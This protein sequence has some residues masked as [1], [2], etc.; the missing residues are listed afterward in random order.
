MESLYNHWTSLRK[1]ELSV[2]SYK[3]A[4]IGLLLVYL[5]V[6]IVTNLTHLQIQDVE[7]PYLTAAKALHESKPLNVVTRESYAKVFILSQAYKLST[8]GPEW[9]QVFLLRLSGLLFGAG[10][11]SLIYFTGKRIFAKDLF[12]PLLALMLLSVSLAFN[13]QMFLMS[14]QAF[15]SFIFAFL[16]YELVEVAFERRLLDLGIALILVFLLSRLQP[17]LIVIS[18]ILLVSTVV[19]TAFKEYEGAIKQSTSKSTN[20]MVTTRIAMAAGFLLMYLAYLA[21]TVSKTV[22]LIDIASAGRTLFMDMIFFFE[23]DIRSL[24]IFLD[25]PYYISIFAGL[26]SII[27]VLFF[28]KNIFASENAEGKSKPASLLV[29][30]EGLFALFLLL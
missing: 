18:V 24:G 17:E 29:A 12:T 3:K 26:L 25:F 27:G 6:G 23:V 20:S 4:F 21:F 15:I 11:L 22:K 8:S 9:L 16:L 14:G 28:I 1:R 10:I 13:T 19:F 30:N 7:T 5:F 2:S